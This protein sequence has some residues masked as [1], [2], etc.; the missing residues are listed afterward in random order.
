MTVSL[1]HCHPPF[2]ES[3][4]L[5]ADNLLT[6]RSHYGII[7]ESHVRNIKPFDTYVSIKE[8]LHA[9]KD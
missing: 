8:Q 4:K 1:L 2:G 9:C 5:G 7:K 3:L 6:T